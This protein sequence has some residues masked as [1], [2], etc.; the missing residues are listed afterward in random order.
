MKPRLSL[1]GGS[2]S[3]DLGLE[4]CVERSPQCGTGAIQWGVAPVPPQTTTPPVNAT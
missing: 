4:R 1:R 3:R 2:D